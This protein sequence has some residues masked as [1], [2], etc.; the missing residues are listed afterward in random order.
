MKLLFDSN[1]LPDLVAAVADLFPGSM[2]VWSAGLGPDDEA[3]WTYARDN[4]FA[5]VSKDSDFYHMSLMRGAPP[6]VAWLRVGNDGTKAIEAT[7]RA[8]AAAL[9]AFDGDLTASFL[10]V[11]R[12]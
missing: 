4:G 6:K 2:H 8:R 10:I 9:H 7:L 3:V 1:L 5:V 11:G 12:P